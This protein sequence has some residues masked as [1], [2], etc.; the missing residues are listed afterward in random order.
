MINHLDGH[1][2]LESLKIRDYE[3]SAQFIFDS[4]CAPS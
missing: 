4:L 2:S 1:K 3:R